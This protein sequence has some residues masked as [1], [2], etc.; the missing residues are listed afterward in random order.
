MQG[1]SSGMLLGLAYFPACS[2]GRKTPEPP[3]S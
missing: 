2:C 3:P 1:S